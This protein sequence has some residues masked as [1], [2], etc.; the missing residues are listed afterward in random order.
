MKKVWFIVSLVLIVVVLIG[1][2]IVWFVKLPISSTE[3]DYVNKRTSAVFGIPLGINKGY[4]D[5]MGNIILEEVSYSPEFFGSRFVA[6]YNEVL[7]FLSG[8]TDYLEFSFH[9]NSVNFQDLSRVIGSLGMSDEEI[10]NIVTNLVS[11]YID[12]I[13]IESFSNIIVDGKIR[14]KDIFYHHAE[15]LINAWIEVSVRMSMLEIELSKEADSFKKKMESVVDSLR[16]EIYSE[17]LEELQKGR[18]SLPSDLFVQFLD[19]EVAVVKSNLTSYQK[20]IDAIYQKLSV[21]REGYKIGWDEKGNMLKRDPQKYID[22]YLANFP[23]YLIKRLVSYEFI[24]LPKILVLENPIYRMRLTNGRV[25]LEVEG[26]VW[27]RS[28]NFHFRGFLGQGKIDGTIGI[29][30]F[31][32]I[33]NIKNV[34]VNFSS[35]LFMDTLNGEYDCKVEIDSGVPEE[36]A[37]S[38]FTNSKVIESVIRELTSEEGFVST[39]VLDEVDNLFR[40]YKSQ[41]E[42]YRVGII[43]DMEGVYREFLKEVEKSRHKLRKSYKT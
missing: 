39:F 37:R 30:S 25:F 42:K 13:S 12:K 17:Y 38:I 10:F 34:V 31:E 36:V 28:G 26:K 20:K 8:I 3:L 14:N 18:T 22:R 29:S 2:F 4:R 7:N 33:A 11:Y 41:Y 9:S 23:Y 32:N 35:K 1:I 15:K 16:Q 6:K 21:L 5:L 19:R 43:K 24:S 40:S 27:G